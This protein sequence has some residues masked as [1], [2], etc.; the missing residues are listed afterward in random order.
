MKIGVVGKGGIGK[1][2]ISAALAGAYVERGRR[3]LAI[4][5]DSN[6]NLALSLGLDE[7]AAFDVPVM[8]RRIIVGSGDGET[9]P[10]DIIDEYGVDTPSGVTVLHAMEIADAGGG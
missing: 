10:A 9:S 1:T 8:P 2:T 5:T 6:P 4:D 7:E 3:V